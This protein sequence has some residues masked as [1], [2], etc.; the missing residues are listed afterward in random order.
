[1]NVKEALEIARKKRGRAR[2]TKARISVKPNVTENELSG[3]ER[4]FEFWRLVCKALRALDAGK[5]ET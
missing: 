3:V 1:M 5:E 4:N 2:I